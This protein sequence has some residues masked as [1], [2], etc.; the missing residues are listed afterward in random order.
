MLKKEVLY[1]RPVANANQA[2]QVMVV[3]AGSRHAG[4]LFR[5]LLGCR[6]SSG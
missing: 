3:V 5:Y 6:S 2:E 4:S 1:L